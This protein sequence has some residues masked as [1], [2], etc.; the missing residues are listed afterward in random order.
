MTHTSSQWSRSLALLALL[1][2]TGAVSGLPQA[3]AATITVNSTADNLT[4]GD[5][6][7][8]LREAIGNVG[9]T[10]FDS[11]GGDCAAGSGGDTI[12]FDLALPAT[13]TLTTSTTLF[14]LNSTCQELADGG[15]PRSARG[16]EGAVDP[17]GA[18]NSGTTAEQS[19]PRAKRGPAP[20]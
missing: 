9:L 11:T 17:K 12:V 14:I 19:G 13:I 10:G 18:A 15:P 7:C 2:F 20:R 8:T 3:R 4:A 1:V 16:P 6:K 5:G